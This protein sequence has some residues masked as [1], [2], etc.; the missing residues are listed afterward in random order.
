M[1]CVI[2][3]PQGTRIHTGELGG[4]FDF[5]A[6]VPN[7]QLGARIQIWLKLEGDNK[8][9]AGDAQSATCEEWCNPKH[10]RVAGAE[11]HCSWCKCAGCNGCT[12]RLGLPLRLMCFRLTLQARLSCG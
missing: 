5:K 7:W 6:R 3:D 12:G 11:D 8:L 1:P 4:S 2:L 9:Q 10:E